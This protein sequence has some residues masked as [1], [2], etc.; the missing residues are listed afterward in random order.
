M[1]KATVINKSKASKLYKTFEDI[2]L[3]GSG[4]LLYSNN[5]AY[6]EQSNAGCILCK[7]NDLTTGNI[8]EMMKLA[9]S[10]ALLI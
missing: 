6:D 5:L 4:I 3:P 2:N 9:R 1:K 10:A 8:N 7:E